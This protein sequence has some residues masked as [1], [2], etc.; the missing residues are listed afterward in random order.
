MTVH[1]SYL[2]TGMTCGHCVSAV[3]AEISG[4]D[5]VT[6]VTVDLVPGAVSTVHVRSD[7][8]LADADVAAAVEEAGYDLVSS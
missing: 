3:S 4:L 8:A 6:E 7:A 1:T 5:G 2:V